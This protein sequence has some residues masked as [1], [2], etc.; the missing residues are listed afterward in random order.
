M[1]SGDFYKVKQYNDMV[2]AF[3]TQ[4]APWVGRPDCLTQRATRVQPGDA[5]GADGAT[6]AAAAHS[7]SAARRTSPTLRAGLMAHTHTMQ[8]PLTLTLALA[9]TTKA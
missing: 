6:G 5:G 2:L 7:L 9:L 1:K 4:G 3:P 8:L